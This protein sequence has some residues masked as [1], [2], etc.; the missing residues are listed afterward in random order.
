MILFCLFWV[1]LFYLLRRQF[2]DGGGSGVWALLFG[3][4]FAVIQAFAGHLVNPGGFDFQRFMYGFIDLVSL[5]VLIPLILYFVIQLLKGFSDGFDFANFALLWLFPIG[6]LRALTWSPTNDPIL[7]VVVPLLWTALAVGIP[8]FINLMINDFRWYKAALCVPF[9]LFLPVLA[10]AVYW[11]FFSHQTVLGFGL[12]LAA[13]IPL[14]L[15]LG[16]DI[17]RK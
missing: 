11:A 13:N 12:L 14:G 17:S 3:S 7:L 4:I 10:A 15:S 1:P 2:S 9:I 8:F 6:L 16:F 5:P